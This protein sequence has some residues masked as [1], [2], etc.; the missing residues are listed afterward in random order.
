MS[1]HDVEE[2]Y[3]IPESTLKKF[4]N[5]PTFSFDTMERIRCAYALAPNELYP[6]EAL[7]PLSSM[8]KEDIK[9]IIIELVDAQISLN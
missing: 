4:E 9:K 6:L 1:V 8:S 5:Q 2:F 3:Q 7:Y